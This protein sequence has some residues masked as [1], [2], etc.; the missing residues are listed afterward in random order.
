MAENC[1]HTLH[2]LY[3][4]RGAQIRDALAWS[5]YINEAL[6]LWGDESDIAFASHHW[7]R[8]GKA[9]VRIFL[10]RQRDVYRWMNDQ[11]MRQFYSIDLPV[12]L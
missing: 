11:T 5:K 12:I 1:T 4:I 8:F 3:P 7:P 9:D 6:Y 10:E 2:N